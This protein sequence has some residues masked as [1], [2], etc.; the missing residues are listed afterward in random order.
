ME[1]IGCVT[2]IF[3]M[4]FWGL[5]MMFLG[6]GLPILGLIVGLVLWRTDSAA[7]GLIALVSVLAIA[8][9][10]PNYM[11]GQ[12]IFEHSHRFAFSLQLQW[13]L[14][15]LMLGYAAFS[16][17]RHEHPWTGT[18]ML[19]LIGGLLGLIINL[20]VFGVPMAFRLLAH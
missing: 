17:T 11:S 13:V 10:V 18:Y 12:S 6:V 7:G 16:S 9:M 1:G 15:A 19:V 3:G 20:L 2:V 14:T 8:A 5:L 4:I